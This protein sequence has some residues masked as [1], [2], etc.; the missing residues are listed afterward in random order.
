M[1]GITPASASGLEAL[2]A[3]ALTALLGDDSPARDINVVVTARTSPAIRVSLRTHVLTASGQGRGRGAI[4]APALTTL[5]VANATSD[6]DPGV[7][8]ASGGAAR[9]ERLVY[10]WPGERTYVPEALNFRLK[11]ADGMTTADGI[12]DM[13]TDFR[14]ASIISNLAPERNPAQT[15]EPIPTLMSSVLAFQRGVSGLGLNEYTALRAAGV[16]ALRLDRTSGP[17]FQSGITTSLISGE[18]NINR[19]RMADFIEDSLAER[20]VSFS[21]LPLTQRLKDAAVG[22]ARAFMN[23]LLSP[24]NTAA[25][26][27]DAFQ[28]DGVSGN[29][30][31]LEAKGI[32]VIIVRVRLTPTADFIVLQAEI[33]ENVVIQQ[34]A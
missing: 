19:R 10:A 24:N 4:I 23:E 16:M 17:I 32:Y 13:R 27:I 3:T 29:T 7:G 11:T 28:V 18:K 26:R 34:A 22:E 20:L 33:G 8:G 2:Y 9:H 6:S 31:A 5:T 21:K 30:P 1:Q 12:L 25:Q 15:A 14:V